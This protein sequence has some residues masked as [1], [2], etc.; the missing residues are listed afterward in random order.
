[1]KAVIMAGGKGTRL[2]PLSCDLPKPMVPVMNRPM[3]EHIISL[4]KTHGITD[5]AVT[6]CHL[7]EVITGYFGDGAHFGVNLRY[8]T[9]LT[10]LGTAGSVHEADDFLDE[11]FLVISGD[12]LTDIDLSLALAFHRE[13][14]ALATLILTR[15]ETPLE[16]GVVITGPDGRIR[17]FLE[18]PGWS[19]VFS[20][21]V[22]T[23]IYV[24][25]P[26][27]FRHYKK[28]QV[29]D[30]SKDLFPKLLAAG[31]PLYGHVAA[32]Y[33][34]DIGHLD[35]YWLSHLDCLEG[36]VRLELPGVHTPWAS[37]KEGGDGVGIGVR[38]G[39]HTFVHPG[40][41]IEPPA[42]IGDY[43]RIEE[44]AHVGP[45][46]VVGDFST[47]KSGAVLSRSVVWK[48]TLLDA[49][50]EVKGAVFA[51]RVKVRSGATVLEGVV[52]GKDTV[53]GPKAFV[54]P[55]V[56]IWPAKNID[57]GV[58]LSTS[59]VWGQHSPTRIFT[60]TGVAGAIDWELT[61]EHAVRVGA[62]FATTRQ[63]GCRLVVG[64]D[65]SAVTRLLK[66][67]LAAGMLSA[68]VNV[69]DLGTATAPV[70]RHAVVA[71]KAAGGGV[72]AS[73]SAGK[74]EK[75]QAC[76][77][78]FLDEKGLFLGRGHLREIESHFLRED[79][80]R[81]SGERVGELTFFPQFI[82]GYLEH[83]LRGID[84]DAIRGARFRLVVAYDDTGP[85]RLVLPALL[86]RMGLA[87]V[88]VLP[89]PSTSTSPVES[90]R[91]LA[92]DIVEVANADLDLGIIFTPDGQG[93][94][95]VDGTG[96]VIHGPAYW[97][98][99]TEIA[100][101]RSSRGPA[102]PGTATATGI[103]TADTSGA[104][105]FPL[106][107]PVFAPEAVERIA[108]RLGGTASLRIVRTK[109]HPRAILEPWTESSPL[110]PYFPAF[111]ALASLVQV[112]DAAA[113]RPGR[114]AELFDL[115]PPINMKEETVDCPW[116]EKGRVMRALADH[117]SP[118]RAEFL[119]GIKVRHDNG[120]ALVLPDSEEPV[121]RIFSE[122]T[123]IDEADALARYYREQILTLRG[124]STKQ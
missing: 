96:R 16:Y 106:P 124:A 13:R 62:A 38:V 27:I 104:V 64:S 98:L 11:T 44:G 88:A 123:T 7:P 109:A 94:S 99:V 57:A 3:L 42:F 67:A 30:F 51:D 12:S 75:E 78:D 26:A 22:N 17:R 74:R 33:W 53:I 79:L 71:L 10:P 49:A 65:G 90:W 6:L 105:E 95:L 45:Y 81:V 116:E 121:F 24:L 117:V 92:D 91:R 31:E 48:E 37:A 72:L 29:F 70:V 80:R 1:M 34:S 25:E 120:W 41:F 119:D 82:D 83:V 56:R 54:K 73:L 59:I 14:N 77:I 101:L 85:L 63:P 46:A 8:Y 114:V 60:S 97:A 55:R 112:L 23:G 15:V 93:L 50:T 5:I 84:T 100:A 36:K 19:E 102:G 108:E 4:L 111:D 21:T 103:V 47:I 20:D 32:G 113:R 115:L 2:Q 86:E 110:C 52:V 118:E 76:R 9:E 69:V 58:T 68:G 40:A 89:I 61:P 107:V 28:G 66:R 39:E 87:P 122:A 18:K 35:Q 43:C